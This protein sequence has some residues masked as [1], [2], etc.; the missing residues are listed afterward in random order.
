MLYNLPHSALTITLQGRGSRTQ[1]TLIKGI[2]GLPRCGLGRMV[3]VL[4]GLQRTHH[5]LSSGISAIGRIAY[6]PS[7]R[8]TYVRK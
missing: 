6:E 3:V 8:H 4:W 5:A 2:V 1:K 7:W